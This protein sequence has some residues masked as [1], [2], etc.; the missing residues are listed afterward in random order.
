MT[1]ILACRDIGVECDASFEGETDDEI[2]EQA[3]K[4]AA[5]EHNMKE[6]P[7][8]IERQCRNAIRVKGDN[9]GR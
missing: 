4:H 3:R 1:K 7:P 6:V 9:K 2:M 8:N 5:S